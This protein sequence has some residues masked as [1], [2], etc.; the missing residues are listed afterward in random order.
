MAR[1]RR[2]VKAIRT[3]RHRQKV[4][5]MIKNLGS[6]NLEAHVKDDDYDNLL[7]Y[8]VDING[9]IQKFVWE[10]G[11]LRSIGKCKCGPH[12]IHGPA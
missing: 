9:R 4:K 12:P 11:L 1:K 10:W 2:S 5:N 7:N 8:I 3:L 6:M